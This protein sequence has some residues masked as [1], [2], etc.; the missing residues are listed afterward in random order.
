[1]TALKTLVGTAG[2]LF[3]MASIGGLLSVIGG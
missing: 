3:Y 2:F 1:M